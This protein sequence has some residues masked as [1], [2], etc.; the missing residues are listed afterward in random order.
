MCLVCISYVYGLF[1]AFLKVTYGCDE[2]D[3]AK[4][5]DSYVCV[6]LCVV[7]PI[8]NK[9]AAWPKLLHEMDKF[10]HKEKT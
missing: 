8:G 1:Y 2:D 6:C 9:M 3:D 7:A 5:I 4:V 10:E